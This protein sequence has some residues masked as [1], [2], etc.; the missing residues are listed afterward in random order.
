MD[1]VFLKKI[2]CMCLLDLSRETEPTK[3]VCICGELYFQEL[4]QVIGEAWLVQNLMNEA[5]RL[6]TQ[7]EL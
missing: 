3:C 1:Q 5:S 6:D 2:L 4:A 7:K